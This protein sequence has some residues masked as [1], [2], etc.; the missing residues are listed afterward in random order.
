MKSAIYYIDGRAYV[1]CGWAGS[2]LAS[3]ERGV[4]IGDC[5]VINGYLVYAVG[6]KKTMFRDNVSWCMYDL[7]DI[8]DISEQNDYIRIFYEKLHC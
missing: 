5:R 6:I 3:K 2:Q 8:K 7:K 4:S 1:K